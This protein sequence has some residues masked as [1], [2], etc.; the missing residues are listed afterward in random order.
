MQ[1]NHIKALPI[2]NTEKKIVDI[3]FDSE[4]EKKRSRKQGTLEKFLLL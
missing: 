1:E 3:V 2:L 4:V